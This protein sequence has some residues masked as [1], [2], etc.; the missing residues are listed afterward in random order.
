MKMNAPKIGAIF[1]ILWGLVH[2]VG[3]VVLLQQL[4][5]EGLTAVLA[6]LGSALPQAELPVISGGVTAAVVAFFAFNWVWIGLLVLGVGLR[7][8]WLNS[9][10]GYWLNLSVAGAS[11]LG[12]FIFLLRPGYMALADGWPGPLL[13]LLAA[14]FSTIGLLNQGLHPAGAVAARENSALPG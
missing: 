8:N 4:S 5:A 2:I 1:Y 11:D 9:P 13:W 3:G 7:L 10:T 12:L 6:S 14:I